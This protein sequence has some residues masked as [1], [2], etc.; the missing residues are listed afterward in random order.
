MPALQYS[1]STT[2]KKNVAAVVLTFNEEYN[3]QRCL[4]RLQWA[5]EIIVVD[6]GSTDQTCA[7]A[8]KAGARVFLQQ[9][10]QF[11]IA[12]QRNWALAYTNIKSDWV[13]FMD[14]DEIV[15]RELETAICSA[16]RSAS[17]DVAAFR[18]CPQFMF[19]GKW[20][21]HTLAFPVW[22]DRLLRRGYVCY[23]G[24]VWEYFETKGNIGY[25]KQPYLHYGFSNGISSWLR[26]HERYAEWKAGKLLE[27]N[28]SGSLKGSATASSMAGWGKRRLHNFM[29]QWGTK[30]GFLSPVLRFFHYY[31]IRLGFLDGLPGLIYSMLMAVYQLMIYLFLLEKREKSA[32]RLL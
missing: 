28:A 27:P 16:V 29:E 2:G 26:K 13:L 21:R 14:A 5:D 3:I 17:A 1:V 9:T 22:H 11:I 12:D 19:M 24:E 6:S 18:L 8:Q 32:G 25:I 30:V 15:T 10:S 20:L 23:T 7:L 4:E 31:I